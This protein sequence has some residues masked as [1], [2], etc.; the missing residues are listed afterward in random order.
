VFSAAACKGLNPFHTR[1][2]LAACAECTLTVECQQLAADAP[3][4][5]HKPQVWG[6]LVLPRES[7]LLPLPTRQKTYDDEPRPKQGGRPTW[8]SR[9]GR[10]AE[11]G[12]PR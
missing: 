5:L 1:E 4:P 2:V 9:I 10:N 7:A 12:G 8:Y 6:G 11:P 3:F